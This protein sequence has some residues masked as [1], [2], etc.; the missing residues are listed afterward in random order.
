MAHICCHLQQQFKLAFFS[1]STAEKSVQR[2]SKNVWFADQEERA[3]CTISLEASKPF[4]GSQCKR[5]KHLYACMLEDCKI[6]VGLPGSLLSNCSKFVRCKMM[7]C[8]SHNSG[9]S[10]RYLLQT[11]AYLQ[12]RACCSF[13]ASACHTHS[14]CPLHAW[15]FLNTNSSQINACWSHSTFTQIVSGQIK[16]IIAGHIERVLETRKRW[17]CQGYD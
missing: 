12:S 17:Q 8:A 11:K 5:W 7:C 2:V 10:R 13:C 6:L 1:T 15:A 16:Q 3:E 9:V 14:V 4:G